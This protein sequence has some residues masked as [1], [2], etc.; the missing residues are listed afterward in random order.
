ME[1]WLIRVGRGTEG[2][3]VIIVCIESNEQ[4]IPDI[5]AGENVRNWFEKLELRCV[6]ENPKR[7]ERR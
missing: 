4:D 1:R 5:V 3:L 2:V 7:C 6:G